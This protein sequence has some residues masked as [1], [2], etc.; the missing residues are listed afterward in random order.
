MKLKN[1]E[2]AARLESII[3][4]LIGARCLVNPF[5]RISKLTPEQIKSYRFLFI[6]YSR[7]ILIFLIFICI[8]MNLIKITLQF[9]LSILFSYQYL[10]FKPQDITPKILFISHGIGA[11]LV[12]ASVKLRFFLMPCS[13]FVIK[14]IITIN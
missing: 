14:P 3:Q 13:I 6:N 1:E 2:I 11:N 4:D 5:F 8:P 9:S 12:L 7:M 10:L